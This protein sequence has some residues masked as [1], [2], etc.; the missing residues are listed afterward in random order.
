MWVEKCT[1]FISIGKFDLELV[2]RLCCKGRYCFT[3]VSN[4]DGAVNFKLQGIWTKK[5]LYS[6]ESSFD[7][8]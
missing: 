8:N 3:Q 7:L 5:K 1:L 6:V 2:A 4:F